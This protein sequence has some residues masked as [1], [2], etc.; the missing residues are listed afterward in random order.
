MPVHL[1]TRIGLLLV[2]HQNKGEKMKTTLIIIGLLLTVP[3]FGAENWFPVGKSGAKTIYTKKS[4]C[5][6]AEGQ[7]CF[8]VTIG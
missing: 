4:K 3:V 7:L 1:K 6:T 8:P 2:S 5:E